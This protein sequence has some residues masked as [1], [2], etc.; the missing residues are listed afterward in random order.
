MWKVALTMAP[1][2]L[3]TAVTFMVPTAATIVEGETVMVC[4]QMTAISGAATLGSEV[5]VIFTTADG[6]GSLVSQF[7]GKYFVTVILRSNGCQWRLFFILHASI[8]CTWFY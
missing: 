5:V 7:S 3:L 6:T 2:F 8:F 1:C 4:V